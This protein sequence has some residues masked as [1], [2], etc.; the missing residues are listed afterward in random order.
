MMYLAVAAA[1]VGIGSPSDLKLIVDGNPVSVA[2]GPP[3]VIEEGRVQVPMRAIFTALG[4]DVQYLPEL[5]Q[6]VA[7]R[8]NQEVTLFL[9]ENFSYINGDHRLLDYPPQVVDGQVMVPLRFVSEALAS[10]VTWSADT[11][12]VTVQANTEVTR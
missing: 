5:R 7:T 6:V 12:T 4:A 3:P 10:R 1:L 8:G 2:G 11:R 9:D